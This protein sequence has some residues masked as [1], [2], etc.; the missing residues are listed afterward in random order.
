[1]P[2]VPLAA[3]SLGNALVTFVRGAEGAPP[4]DAPLPLALTAL[5]LGSRVLMVF[6]RRR[7]CWELPGGIIEPGETPRE[8]ALRELLEESGQRPDG[9]LRFTGYAGFVL[10]PDRRDEYGALFTGTIAGPRVFR[11]NDEIS[12]VRWW[13]LRDRLPGR[14]S[15]LDAH[16]AALARPDTPPV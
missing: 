12:A 5:R 4:G 6:D 16:L 15:P 14:T 8:A 13:N 10:G 7:Q 2:F 9:P 11:P 3:D 1:M